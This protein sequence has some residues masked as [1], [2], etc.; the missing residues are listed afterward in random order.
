MSFGS[1]A[2][3]CC[4]MSICIW[5]L[6]SNVYKQPAATPFDLQPRPSIY[7]TVLS[8]KP[9]S[10]ASTI[11]NASFDIFMSKPSRKQD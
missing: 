8:D 4:Q 10:K 1:F 3:S 2:S 6:N 9:F 11:K 7:L 5:G